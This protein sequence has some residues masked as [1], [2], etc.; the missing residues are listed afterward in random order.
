[1]G[2]H[3]AIEIPEDDISDAEEMADELIEVAY[4]AY[5]EG[6]DANDIFLAFQ[7]VANIAR[8]FDTVGGVH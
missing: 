6:V 8:C 5:L 7:S 3:Q 1:M 4:Q 2:M